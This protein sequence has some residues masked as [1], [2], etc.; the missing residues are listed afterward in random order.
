MVRVE[1]YSAKNALS[2]WLDV[3]LARFK[4]GDASVWMPVSGESIDLMAK[5]DGRPVLLKEPQSIM[6]LRVVDGTIEFNKHPGPEVFTVRSKPGMPR[7]ES[8]R[9]LESEYARQQVKLNPGNAMILSKYG[10]QGASGNDE[11]DELA[12]GAAAGA[13]ARAPDRVRFRTWI[14]WAMGALVLVCCVGAWIWSRRG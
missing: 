8:F 4:V 13:G 5:G 2:G 6:K 10:V 14:A 7:T 1:H 12:V 9:K 3:E 11:K